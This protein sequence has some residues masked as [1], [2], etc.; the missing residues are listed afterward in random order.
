MICIVVRATTDWEDVAGVR[1]QLPKG[2]A[3]LVDLW[4]E[5]F[6]L[7]YHLF[8]HELKRIAELSWSRAAPVVPRGDVPEGAIVVPTDDD[9]WF[10]PGLAAA[11]EAAPGA[12][13]WRW[14]SRYLEVPI[15]LRHRL[16]RIRRRLF[17][18]TPSKWICTTNNYAVVHG[19][20]PPVLAGNHMRASEWFEAHAAE[21]RVLAEPLSVMN[22]T[23]ASITTLA[24]GGA[25]SRARLLRKYRSYARLYRK[26]AD[27][28]WA[29]PYVAAMAELMDR[30]RPR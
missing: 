30:L 21:V 26:R 10:A 1:A 27:P 29:A 25:M 18:R 20:V 9:D 14:P 15:G 16:G 8:R 6:T 17:P 12:S 7:P 13:G 22:R 28:A 5:T 24:C 11:L 19:A 23:L 2:F 4:D 3:P